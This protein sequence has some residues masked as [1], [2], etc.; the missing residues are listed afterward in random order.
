LWIFQVLFNVIFLASRRNHN[1]VTRHAVE[2]QE[3][4]FFDETK[5]SKVFSYWPGVV[6]AVLRPGFVAVYVAPHQA[7]VIP[8]RSFASRAQ[9]LAFIALVRDKIRAAASL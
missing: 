7:H 3:D 1:F 4:A 5:F 6:R 2:V 8:N 9:K